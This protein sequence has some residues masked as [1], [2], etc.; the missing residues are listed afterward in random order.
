MTRRKATIA[1]VACALLAAGVA[2]S[3]PAAK[4]GTLKGKV[5]SVQPE[6]KVFAVGEDEAQWNDKSRIHYEGPG[7]KADLKDGCS[8]HIGGEVSEDGTA[9][10]A[11]VI[12]V[13]LDGSDKGKPKVVGRRAVVRCE[14]R[15]DGDGWK[16]SAHGRDI[17]INLDAKEK[18]SYRLRKQADFEDLKVGDVVKVRVVNAESE[19]PTV[20]WALLRVKEIPKDE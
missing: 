5:T 2:T 10:D 17:K 13:Y 15:K 19:I 4:T 12:T 14:L 3:A 6:R 8:A 11:Q 18:T 1:S 16:T 7:T 20:A 9:I